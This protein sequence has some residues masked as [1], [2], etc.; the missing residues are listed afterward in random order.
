MP[1]SGF[2]SNQLPIQ[3]IFRSYATKNG[4]NRPQNK[5]LGESSLLVQEGT[6]FQEVPVAVLRSDPC[7]NES[8]GTTY[9]IK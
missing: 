5:E 7:Q 9:E 1:V 2:R 6:E 4:N 8:K 3:N